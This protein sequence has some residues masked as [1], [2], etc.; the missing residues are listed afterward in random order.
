M[1]STML[2]RSLR[3]Q[4]RRPITRIVGMAR[5]VADGPELRRWHD[6]GGK[7]RLRLDYELDATSTVIDV[8]GHRGQFASDI[9]SRFLCTVHIFEPI[10][11]FA[12]GIEERFALNDRVLVHPFGLGAAALR[13][14][15][16]LDDDRTSAY[17]EG[18]TRMLAPI[19]DAVEVFDELGL[20]RIDLMKINIEGAEYDL[21]DHLLAAGR[22]GDVR[23]L[24]I[25]FHDHVA[26]AAARSDSIRRQLAATHDEMWRYPFVWESW[27]AR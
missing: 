18:G 11:R 1:I 19:R 22:I 10:P 27:Q 21:L 9:F 17:R 6:D 26:N 16:A 24:Q 4:V 2:G 12:S 15:F 20:G 25:Q 23:Y 3:R 5:R 14:S 7:D 8:G 13:T